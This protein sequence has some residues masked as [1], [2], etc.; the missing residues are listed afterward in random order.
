MARNIALI[1]GGFSGEAVISYKSADT[2]AKHIDSLLWTCYT[3]DIRADGWY[4]LTEEHERIV[5]D[6]NDFSITVAGKKIIFEAVLTGLHGTPAEDGKI[7]GYFDCLHIPYTCCDAA[8]AALTFNK[9]YTVAVAASA[10]I[11]VAKSIQ[12]FTNN[13]SSLKEINANL[14]FPVFVKPNNGGSSI[15]MSK[16]SNE[17]ELP[18]AVAKAFAEDDQVLVEEFIRGREFTIGVYRHGGNIVTLPITEIIS[19]ND[20]F[21]FEAK[22]HGASNEVTPAEIDQQQTTAIS[23]MAKKVYQVFNCK[24]VVRIDF[25]FDEVTQ[26]PVMLEIN[27]VPGQSS[28]S[29]IP[30]Q[31]VAAGLSLKEFYSILLHECFN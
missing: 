11:P 14:R 30:Q 23:N 31:V 8:T 4:Y 6:K 7:L 21:D 15:G 22:Y 17:T 18:T 16:V 5:I 19:N 25:I 29:I 28:A 2:I 20:F 13:T 3:I 1:T 12:L 26:Q 24:A 9:K 27:T 10:G